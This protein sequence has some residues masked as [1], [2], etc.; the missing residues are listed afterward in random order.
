VPQVCA[1]PVAGLKNA[2]AA[3]SAAI[4]SLPPARRNVPVM[5][6]PLPV[7]VTERRGSGAAERFR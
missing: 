7:S 2:A 3:A 1:E 4:T 5:I 6:L